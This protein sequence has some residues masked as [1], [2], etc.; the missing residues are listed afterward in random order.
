LFIV[1]FCH[2]TYK[3]RQNYFQVKEACQPTASSDKAVAVSLN[4]EKKF[5]LFCGFY[6]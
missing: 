3:T 5:C 1:D 6:D 4:Q 2:K